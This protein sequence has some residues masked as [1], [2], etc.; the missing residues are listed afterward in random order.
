M[1]LSTLK[2]IVHRI[3]GICSKLQNNFYWYMLLVYIIT[4][5]LSAMLPL[6]VTHIFT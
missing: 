3:D 6:A 1:P 2:F 4:V 5:I